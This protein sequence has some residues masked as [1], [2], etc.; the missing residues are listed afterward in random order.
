[1]KKVL[2]ISAILLMLMG[3]STAATAATTSKAGVACKTV[4]ATVTI[5]ANTQVNKGLTYTCTKSGNKT[6]FDK[7]TPAYRVRTTLNLSQ[8][9]Q[10]NSVSLS[11]LD[12]SGKVCDTLA[13]GTECSGFYIGW[14]SNFNDST[15]NIVSANATSSIG[16][17]NLGDKGAFLL[18]YQQVTG[19][20]GTTPIVV[21]E[22]PFDFDY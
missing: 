15:K 6:A 8:T 2:A 13:V 21:K 17:F 20:N 12:S 3:G 22:Y 7:G 19:P 14:R 10:G 16:G 1:M 11:I 4:G 5:Y 9:W 18:M